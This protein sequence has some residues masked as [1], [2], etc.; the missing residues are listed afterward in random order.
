MTNGACMVADIETRDIYRKE[1]GDRIAVVASSF[2][3]KGLAPSAA[4]ITLE[5]F[6]K[7]IAGTVKVPM[8]GLNR[9]ALVA[10]VDFAW[11]VTG[12][13]SDRAIDGYQLPEAMRF[14]RGCAEGIARSDIHGARSLTEHEHRRL[15][16]YWGGRMVEKAGEFDD[17]ATIR[18][19]I[20]WAR[21]MM[22]REIAHRT[23]ARQVS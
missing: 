23:S 12:E 6:N 10:K 5:Q 8:C 16:T 3:T 9:L 1:L 22:T 20:P 4:G 11:L 18:S 2:D 15:V 14:A 21:L 19:L 7:W 13:G 17:P